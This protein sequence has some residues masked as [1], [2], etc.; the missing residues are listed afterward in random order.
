MR[1]GW[2][3]GSMD[4]SAFYSSLTPEFGPWNPQW[5]QR[6]GQL[7]SDL[8]AFAMA[9]ALHVH[10][11]HACTHIHAR[12][13]TGVP[14]HPAPLPPTAGAAD[15]ITVRHRHGWHTSSFSFW[16]LTEILKCLECL[17]WVF[18][19]FET[20]SC[21]VDHAAASSYSCPP[22]SVFTDLQHCSG[23]LG[24]VFPSVLR[25]EPG[26]LSMQGKCSITGPH[27]LSSF[28]FET[29]CSGWP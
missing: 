5:K 25:I 14:S 20:R 4:K 16:F 10:T 23:G 3:D 12:S 22:A 21:Y 28:F 6:L 7:S 26:A 9:Q 18:V 27:H 19:C 24:D 1:R 15:V 13:Q 17:E 29:I 2:Q 8:S 11:P